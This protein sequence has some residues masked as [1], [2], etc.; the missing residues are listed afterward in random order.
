MADVPAVVSQDLDRALR[1]TGA[2]VRCTARAS[3]LLSSLLEGCG[4]AG[5]GGLTTAGSGNGDER[6]GKTEPKR[7]HRQ[8]AASGVP[9]RAGTCRGAGSVRPGAVSPHSTTPRRRAS[10]MW[11]EI[12][13]AEAGFGCTRS[14]S[15]TRAFTR[16]GSKRS[17]SVELRGRPRDAH[18]TWRGA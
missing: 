15:H 1:E 11:V 7:R 9:P 3:L 10:K 12:S 17:A 18:A 2:E 8:P 16:S 5:R 13:G 4:G 6:F 14:A